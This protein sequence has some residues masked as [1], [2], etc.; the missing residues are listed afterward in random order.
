M[1]PGTVDLPFCSLITRL[2]NT[3]FVPMYKNEHVSTVLGNFSTQSELTSNAHITPIQNPFPEELWHEPEYPDIPPNFL[4]IF[5]PPTG[6]HACVPPILSQSVHQAPSIST[7]HA[8]PPS[9]SL[10]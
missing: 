2:L 9:D 7:T 3:R 10:A 5:L 8:E 6:P 1:P 4:S